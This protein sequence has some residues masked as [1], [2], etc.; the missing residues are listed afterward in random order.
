MNSPAGPAAAT[1]DRPGRSPV[2]MAALVTFVWAIAALPFVTGVVQCPSARLLHV[3]CP[4]CGMTRALHLLVEGQV[5]ASLSM[6]ALAVPT[7]V[8]QAI[9][10]VATI[11]STLKYGVPWLVVRPRWGRAAIAFVAIVM[12][13]D[14]LFWIARALGAFGGPVPV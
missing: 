8:S 13:L 9:F 2:R 12:I 6:H 14:I 11:A 7:L 3:P 1:P 4:G 5:G 10:A